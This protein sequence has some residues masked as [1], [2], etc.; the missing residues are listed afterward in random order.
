MAPPSMALP[1]DIQMLG[2]STASAPRDQ[3]ALGIL[4]KTIHRELRQSGLAPEEVMAVAG[5]L[6]SLVAHDL[7]DRRE[8]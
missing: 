2:N 4:A 5:E 1:Q 7:K 8:L 6:L 3:R